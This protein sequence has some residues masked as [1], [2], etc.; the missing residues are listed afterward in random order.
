MHS[1]RGRPVDRSG[2]MT[3][4][5]LLRA[6]EKLAADLGIQ[7]LTEPGDFRGGLC[8]IGDERLILLA[9]RATVPERIDQLAESVAGFDLDGIYLLPRV[10]AAV[11]MARSKLQES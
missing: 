3:E 10:R 5:D 2:G 7:V 8:R 4:G 1:S 9:A 6:L 11:E